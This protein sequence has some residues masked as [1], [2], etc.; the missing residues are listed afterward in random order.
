MKQLISLTAIILLFACNRNQK[1]ISKNDYSVFMRNGVTGKEVNKANS[2]L[3]FWKERLA[4]D[5]GNFLNMKLLAEQHSRLFKLTGNANELKIADSLLLLS[6]KKVNDSEASILYALSQNA[7]IQHH[8]KDA[9]HFN[10]AAEKINSDP[11][12]NNLL[13]FD[14]GMELGEYYEASEKIA[15]LKDKKSFDYLIRK[16]KLED[17]YGKIDKA[18]ELMEQASTLVK[19]KRK[20]AYLW[21]LSNLADMY[22][23]SGRVKDAYKAYL[24]VLEMDSSNLYCLKGIA[25]IA[26]SHDKNATEAK[27]ILSYILSQTNMPEINLILA[28]IAEWEG[29]TKNKESYNKKFLTEILKPGYGDMYN[30]YLIHLY[31]NDLKDYNKALAIALSEIERRPTPETYNW[32]A[33]VYYNNGEIEKAYQIV[34]DYVNKKSFEPEALMNMGFINAAIGKKNEA[35]KLL[36]TCL[37][38]SFELGPVETQKIKEKLKEII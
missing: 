12:I 16:A 18:I 33:Y 2:E 25:W 15:A 34:R 20:P 4:G 29:D 13:H 5:T 1:I 3:N 21:S 38:S 26:Y 19:E 36:S 22:G 23:H 24:K 8:F 30:K 35:R 37:E 28:D 9:Y 14:A 27:R 17:H 11:Y 7:I 10:L 6:T 32:L 31:T